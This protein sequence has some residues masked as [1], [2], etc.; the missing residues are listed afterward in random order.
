MKI[1]CMIQEYKRVEYQKMLNLR[2][3]ID[4]L[5]IQSIIIKLS[6]TV[7][8]RWNQQDKINGLIDEYYKLKIKWNEIF[9]QVRIIIHN[10][11]FGYLV[12]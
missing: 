12:R 7:L 9:Q 10:K 2:S 3:N 8:E 5:K 11:W 6:E 1:Q 4:D